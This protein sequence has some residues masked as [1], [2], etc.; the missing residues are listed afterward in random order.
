[1]CNLLSKLMQKIDPSML[2]KTCVA[3]LLSLFGITVHS[4]HFLT[5]KITVIQKFKNYTVVINSVRK[6]LRKS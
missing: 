2:T 4:I 3:T 1:M 6:G 5:K